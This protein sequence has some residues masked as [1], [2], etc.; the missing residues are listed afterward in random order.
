MIISHISKQEQMVQKFP[1]KDS[2]PELLNFRTEIEQLNRKFGKCREESL[3]RTE[4][5][6]KKFPKISVYVPRKVKLSSFRKFH[7]MR[8]C[9]IVQFKPECLLEWEVLIIV[10]N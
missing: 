10:S 7:I 6:N 3:D 9:L 8:F 2:K 4:I 1:G 5:S